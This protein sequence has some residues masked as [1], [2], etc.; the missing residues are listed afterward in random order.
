[1]MQN[2]PNPT[3]RILFCS[4]AILA[5]S[6]SMQLAAQD[7]PAAPVTPAQQAITVRDDLQ[8]T[9]VLSEARQQLESL[10][11]LTC[12]LHETVQ[13]SDLRFYATGRYHQATGNRVRLEFQMYPI[14]NVQRSDAESLAI[15]G[16]PED[17][18]KQ[19]PTGEL[20]QVSNGSNLWT[21]W[22]NADSR[23]LERRNLREILEA[24]DEAGKFDSGQLLED[25]G[26]GGLQTLLAR[27]E[28]GMEFGKVRERTDGDTKL[29]VLSGRWTAESLKKYFKLQ[30]PT[31]A[32]PLWIPDYVRVYLDAETL[33]PR[34][35][36]YLKKHPAPGRKQ[37]SRMITLVFREM[38]INDAIDETLFTFQAPDDLPELDVTDR[39]IKTIRNA[40]KQPAA[41]P[42]AVDGVQTT[43]DPSKG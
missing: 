36:E 37:V 40:V 4:A 39:T 24:A 8:A 1:M 35:L 33:L 38:T 25:L 20:L 7:D 3:F 41:I 22:K 31:A 26:A 13:L 32:L 14:R 42:N 43:Q 23:R 21:L 10:Q 16:T 9:T 19:K 2:P 15:G 30:D 27:I 34:R 5:G 29:L 11:S 18:G 12:T 6:A 28:I 17:P